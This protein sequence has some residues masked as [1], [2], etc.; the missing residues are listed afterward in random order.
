MGLSAEKSRSRS[1]SFTLLFILH[2]L[3]L[4]KP[5][6]PLHIEIIHVLFRCGQ[7]RTLGMALAGSSAYDLS[8]CNQGVSWDRDLT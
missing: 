4:N 8:D 5:L 7:V 2:L 1:H 6:K 3:L